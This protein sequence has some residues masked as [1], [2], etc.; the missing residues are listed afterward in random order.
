MN[1]EETVARARRGDEAAFAELIRRHHAW[2]M[3]LCASTLGDRAQA[4]D[5]AQDIFLKAYRSLERFQGTASFSTWLHRIAVNRCLDLLRARARRKTESWDALLEDEG[6]RIHQLL[7]APPD[8]ERR[9]EDADLVARVMAR[10]PPAYRVALTLREVQ[11]LSYAE[12]A[13]AMSCSLDS[14]KAR[15]RRA[16]QVFQERLRH[17]TGSMSV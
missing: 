17:L 14:V 16:R 10:L 5:A 1:D 15:L 3:G 8:E 4:E 7:V 11:G 6:E 2:V 12:I 9:R 13:E